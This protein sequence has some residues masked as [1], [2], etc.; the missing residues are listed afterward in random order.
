MI[1]LVP[2]S[3]TTFSY[4][5]QNIIPGLDLR[6]RS[7]PSLMEYPVP[8]CSLNFLLFFSVHFSYDPRPSHFQSRGVCSR[9]R[10]W[11]SPLWRLHRYHPS[12][13][14][15]SSRPDPLGRFGKYPRAAPKWFYPFGFYPSPKIVKS[16]KTK[17]ILFKCSL[18]WKHQLMAAGISWIRFKLEVFWMR[19]HFPRCWNRTEFPCR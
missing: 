18:K 7:L 14:R 17:M 6:Y 11:Q 8:L 1:S 10:S 9:E 16:F 13:A 15:G 4:L 5:E 12:H 19:R 3:K 2:F